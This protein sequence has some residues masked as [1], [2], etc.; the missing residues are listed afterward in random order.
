MLRPFAQVDVFTSVPYLGN[1]LAVVVDGTGLT[2]AQ[3]QHIA[4]W[5]NLSETTFLLPPAH[6]DA[7]YAV[8]IFT[9]TA[10]LP[11]A[12]HPTLG[13]CHAWL[14]AGGTPRHTDRVVQ[15]CGIGLVTI[16]RRADGSLAFAAPALLRS[17]PPTDG[18][19]DLAIRALGI[20][21]DDVVD[22]AWIDNGPGWLG[23]L[24][25]SADE[26]LALQPS[27]CAL[28]LGVVG[29]YPDGHDVA[30]EVRAFFPVGDASREDPV[31]GSL[32]ASAAQWMIGSGRARPP[33]EA[34][35]GARLGRA[36]RVSITV[37][38]H[39][40]VWVGGRVVSCVTGV[41]DL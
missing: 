40:H 11:F 8:R 26:V 6:A 31:T 3:M 13:S 36:G 32:H 12:G 16:E 27:H 7:D 17:G 18:D 23:I 4:H 15:E 19:L 34:T 21:R 14:E 28:D 24:L 10:E 9:P 5:T 22:A 38:E 35:Q 33:Y 37:D 30:Y 29:P 20:S 39:G 2:T 25:R 1:P 41:I